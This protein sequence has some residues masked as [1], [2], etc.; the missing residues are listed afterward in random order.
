[1]DCWQATSCTGSREGP[2]RG[3]QKC[4]KLVEKRHGQ[5]L[6]DI[7]PEGVPNIKSA[8]TAI[9]SCTGPQTVAPKGPTHTFKLVE[10]HGKSKNHN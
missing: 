8:M 10:N 5:K 9:L 3:P 6:V 7:V 2:K 4:I 1:M